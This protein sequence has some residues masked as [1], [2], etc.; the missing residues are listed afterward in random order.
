VTPVRTQSGNVANGDPLHTSLTSV[1]SLGLQYWFWLQFPIVPQEQPA[2]SVFKV[3]P[4]VL[5]A[6]TLGAAVVVHL[7]VT[8]TPSTV[9]VPLQ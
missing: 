9:T 6:L 5:H 3:T 8:S 7:S 2:A 1:P 4:S